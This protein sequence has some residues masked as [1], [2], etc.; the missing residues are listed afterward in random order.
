[1]EIWRKVGN[2]VVVRGIKITGSWSLNGAGRANKNPR[3]RLRT[4][5]E[6]GAMQRVWYLELGSCLSYHDHGPV[7]HRFR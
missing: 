5:D 4:Q 7:R 6:D 3:T 2:L 1:M